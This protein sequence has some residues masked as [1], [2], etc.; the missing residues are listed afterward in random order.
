M[1]NIDQRERDVLRREQAL[2]G[3]KAP[4]F[5]KF[6]PIIYYS[7]E[8]EIPGNV[9]SLIYKSL[10]LFYL[11]SL[12]YF[13][14]LI[15]AIAVLASKSENQVPGFLLAIL[16]VVLLIPSTFYFQHFQLYKALRSDSSL[17]FII[18]FI[19]GFISLVFYVFLIIGI[20]FGGGQGFVVMLDMFGAG[21]VPAG[22]ICAVF[23][24][25]MS[26]ATISLVWMLKLVQSHYRTSGH[27]VESARNE[28]LVAGAKNPTVR[29]AAFTAAKNSV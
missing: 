17:S 24:G 2:K 3:V 25:L 4:N 10:K 20:F 16:Y 1:V 26:F 19:V 12:C 18:Y 6:K 28:A 15:A 29:N 13:I 27:T 9:Q 23:V 21:F 22:I 5:P 7:I 8:E 14:N 11:I